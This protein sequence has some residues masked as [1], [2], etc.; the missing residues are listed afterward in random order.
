MPVVVYSFRPRA[1][2][3]L[4]GLTITGLLFKIGADAHD[5]WVGVDALNTGLP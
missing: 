5:G 4:N 2:R 1:F 3:F